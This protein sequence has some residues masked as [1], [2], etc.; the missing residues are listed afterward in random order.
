MNDL[1]IND[2]RIS[3]ILAIS[4]GFILINLPN[5]F[6]SNAK[7]QLCGVSLSQEH[8]EMNSLTRRYKNTSIQTHSPI[9]LHR[10]SKMY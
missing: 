10:Q 9:L 3:A 1:S 7:K 4:I 8:I 2:L 6:Y 5:N